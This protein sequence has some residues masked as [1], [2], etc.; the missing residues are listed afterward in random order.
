MYTR[1]ELEKQLEEMGIP[2][3]GTLLVHSSMRAI[4]PVE[5]GAETVLDALSAWMEPGLLVFP[6]HTW[7]QINGE[8]PVY[9]P[10]GEPACVGLLPNLF[11]KR[12]GVVRSLHPTHSVAALGAEAEE[13]TRGRSSS[14]PH[15]PG[16]AAGESY[17]TAPRGSCFWGAA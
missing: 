8:N 3:E 10:L 15:A 2:R 12:P 6:T 4:G 13:F 5:G 9:D 7:Q 16:A 1:Q 14:T 17:W 11:L